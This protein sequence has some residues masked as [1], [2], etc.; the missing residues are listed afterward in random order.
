MSRDAA[1]IRVKHCYRFN[2]DFSFAT[3]KVGFNFNLIWV[4]F[5]KHP[6]LGV[7]SLS[8]VPILNQGKIL[9][10]LNGIFMSHIQALLGQ[11]APFLTISFGIAV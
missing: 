3:H 7:C 8:I 6:S 2:K 11:P 10:K 1:E 9:L 5:A 4:F